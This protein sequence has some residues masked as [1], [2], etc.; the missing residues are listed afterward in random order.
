MNEFDTRVFDLL[1]AYTPEPRRWPDWQDVLRRARTRNAR[2]LV[3]ALAAAVAVL[4]C[5]AGVTAAL[6][7]FHAWLSGSPGKPAP[8]AEQ[9]E[10]R[11]AN[12]HSFAGFPKDTRLR[13]LIRTRVDGKLYVL[14]G[15]RSGSSL[16][17]RL[18]AVT[19]GHSLGPT[20]A[21]AARLVHA[22]APILPVVG[23]GGFSD[24]HAQPSAA[25]SYGIA[26]DGVSRVI[27]HAIDGDH[28]AEL[29]GNAY[30]WVQNEP[31]SGQHALS[32]TAVASSGTR[33]TLP[34]LESVGMFATEGP[35]LRRPRGPTR[36]QRRI[37]H[38]TVGW[39]LRGEKR[40][41]GLNEVHG[42]ATR[43]QGAF[44]DS[45][46]LVKPDPASNLLVGLAGRWCIVVVLRDAS[47]PST[48][49]DSSQSFWSRGPLNV[50]GTGE[51]DQ[52][53]R[54]SGVAADGVKRIVVF[55]ADGQRQQAALRDNLFTVLVAGAEFP[56]RLVAYDAAGRIV[57]IQTPPWV[58]PERVPKAATRLR[59]VLR[60][61][62]PEGTAAVLRV[63]R[64]VRGYR[65]WRVDFS[66][67]QSPGACSGTVFTAP[68]IW[69]DLVQPA[70]HDLFVIGHTVGPITRVQLEFPNGDVRTTRP[71][72]G[73]FVIA[74]PR[75]HLTRERQ[76]TFVVG[77][78]STGSV[79]Q[80]KGVVF[81]L[82]R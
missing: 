30:L 16:C 13:E 73:L 68:S 63:G 6:G 50:I 55:L 62:G 40:G 43:G 64:R 35:A 8:K 17:L 26:A 56:A 39:Y 80:R 33:I 57:G 15:F 77:Y 41:V 75:S 82:T 4:G 69:P 7:G 48:G 24:R 27:V 53:V 19:L 1:D 61:Q 72:A 45:T 3:V 58:L 46:R 34:I 79:I 5:A 20:C 32:I 47:G 2:R 78:A 74:V 25:V 42:I 9:A 66:T 10:F 60:I 21:P 51:G 14:L 49:C 11:A 18:T 67:G 76:S 71:V 59:P 38:P 81:R 70:G 36:I 52:F 54:F 31:N 22:T 37:L 12:E 23:V 29:E 28:R 65:C 44:D